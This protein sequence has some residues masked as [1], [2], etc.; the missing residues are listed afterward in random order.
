MR[1]RAQ[2]ARW[3]RANQV[4][5]AAEYDGERHNCWRV[6]FDGAFEG[7]GVGGR[8]LWLGEDELEVVDKE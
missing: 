7:G 4:G 5:T 1:V 6:E 2:P 8:S 3:L